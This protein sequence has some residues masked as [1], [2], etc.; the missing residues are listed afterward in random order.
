MGCGSNNR[1][2]FIILTWTLLRNDDIEFATLKN[3]KTYSLSQYLDFVWEH[4]QKINT[5]M[6]EWEAER[7]LF[8]DIDGWTLVNAFNRIITRKIK[9]NTESSE[10]IQK[11]IDKFKEI[12]SSIQNKKTK[13]FAILLA[14]DLYNHVYKK[15]GRDID[16]NKLAFELEN[17]WNNRTNGNQVAAKGQIYTHI[18]MKNLIIKLISEN[19]ERD[20]TCYDPTCGTGGFCESFYRYCEKQGDRLSG[21]TAFGNE[22]DNDCSNLAWINGLSSNMD[23]R[24]FNYDC[25]DPE[26]KDELIEGNSIDFLLMNP[27]FGMNKGK[28]LG[29]PQGFHW[30]EDADQR[31]AI[32]PTEWTFCRYN[33]ESFVKQG[34]W[35]A[36][37]IPVSCVS[38]NKQNVY[39]KQRMIEECEIWFV[40]K[41]REDIFTPQ[42][43]KACCLVI[44]RYLNGLRT[45]EEIN[46]WKTKC[47]DFT[48]DGGEVKKKKGE[49]E[50]D[51]KELEKLWLERIMDNKELEGINEE[52]G[53]EETILMSLDYNTN[54]EGSKWYEERVLKADENWIFTKRDDVDVGA[55]KQKFYQSVEDRRHECMSSIVASMDWS[56]L[57]SKENEWCEWRDVRIDELFELVKVKGYKTSELKDGPYPLI[58]SMSTN[59]GIQ[60]YVDKYVL[61]T[62]ELESLVIT[63]AMKGSTGYCFVQEGKFCLSDNGPPYV[64]KPRDKYKYLNDALGLLAFIMT[65]KFTHYYNYNNN[66][67]YDRLHNE[68]IKLPHDKRTGKL[69]INATN[70]FDLTGAEVCRDVRVDELFEYVSRGKH[71]SPDLK[72]GKYPFI[73]CSGHNNGIVRYVENYAYDGTYLTVA[74]NGDATAGM[75]FVQRGKFDAS[76][77][78]HVLK[79]KPEYQ[80]LEE[81]LSSLAFAMTM[82]FRRKYSYSNVLS[83]TRL[84]DESI[85]SIPYCQ[86]PKDPTN[87][88]I[89][90]SGLRYIYIYNCQGT[91]ERKRMYPINIINYYGHIFEGPIGVMMKEVGIDELFEVA[92]RGVTEN[93]NLPDGPYPL[94]SCSSQNNGIIHYVNRYD[95]D[96]DFISVPFT[97]SVGYCFA[98][99]GK[100]TL[101]HGQ[102]VLLKLKENMQY[103]T[104][105]LGVFAFLMTQQFTK[106]YGYSSK[107][108]NTRL[109]NESIRLP[110]VVRGLSETQLKDLVDGMT[111]IEE[112]TDNG[113][114]DKFEYEINV[115]LLNNYVMTTLM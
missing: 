13:E 107:L 10:A 80:Q 100:L 11:Q 111:T 104:D 108:T 86:D 68:T 39:D 94:L 52:L 37:V 51:T 29:M 36:F 7:P 81:C 70:M 93:A 83:K 46:T 47:V 33:L 85:H 72:D 14:A 35:F 87:M 12:I 50:Y 78:V 65:N 63:V 44:G 16:M 109:M 17:K 103:L 34:G 67:T 69:D 26:I 66:I 2:T 45:M 71:N 88:I 55:Q 19:I 54:E 6:D 20:S 31:R 89:D 18:M 49:V 110:V 105:V 38:E 84:M 27:P 98:Q 43:G 59:N 25:F 21:I 101:S 23:V 73:S 97:G 99:K 42:A 3:G 115:N 53:G 61:D 102:V 92:G 60:R 106:K 1:T 8:D 95:Y 48:Q 114:S 32:K 15:Y 113:N 5:D 4:S 77:N 56:K 96:G 41:I 90:V 9:H 28:F 40:I 30:E 58:M 82:E 24:V 74:S 22:I 76:I 57:N 64:L 75:C 62:N 91:N 79:L 112:L